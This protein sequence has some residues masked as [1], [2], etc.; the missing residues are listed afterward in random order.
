MY[1]LKTAQADLDV[2]QEQLAEKQKALAEVE[3]K[4]CVCVCACACAC[5]CVCVS[6]CVRVYVYSY[7][8]YI[9]CRLQSC[10]LLMIRVWQRKRNSVRTYKPQV[11]D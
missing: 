2:V 3:A 6:A 10:K 11:I 8:V 1:R 4:V 7:M 9:L 5:A